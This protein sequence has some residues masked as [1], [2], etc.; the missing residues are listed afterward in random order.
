MINR[1]LD[2]A[3]R[4]Y[5][6]GFI[7]GTDGNISVRLD[8]DHIL[9]TPSGF[10]KG[11]LDDHDLVTVN[12]QGTIV[13]GEK[14]P[15]SELDMHL[16]IYRHRPDCRACVHAHPPY[17]TAFALAHKPLPE[18]LLPEVVVFV[19]PIALTEFAPPGT[20]AVGTSL[21]P[22]IK[23]HNAFLLANHGLLTTG[24]SLEEAYNRH[25]TVEHYARI[26]YLAGRIGSAHAI[27][28]DELT[29]LRDMRAHIEATAKRQS[30]E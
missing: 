5:D 3:R 14:K 7:A 21:D 10:R 23:T 18:T 28:E 9:V 24:G 13:A 26:V 11:D 22:F 25:E 17:A 15:S 12:L 19:G 20:S 4:L 2:C 6:K 27:P 8:D 29:R 16:H 30:P 1:F